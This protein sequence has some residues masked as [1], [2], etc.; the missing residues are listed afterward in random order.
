MIQTDTH[1]YFMK[2]ALQ[3]AQYAQHANEVPIGAVIVSNNQIIAKAHNQVQT[4]HDTT[5]HAEIIAITAATNYLQAKYLP[6]C[7]LYVTLEPCPMCAAAMYWAQLGS[8]IYATPDTKRGYTL[9]NP[10][11]LHPK[12]TVI[13]NILPQPCQQ[14]LTQF[15]KNKR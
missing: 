2:Q 7:S 13:N 15:F 3:Q 10:P 6:Q 12:T 5:A 8:L 14:L 9:F 11:L 1:Q 4:L